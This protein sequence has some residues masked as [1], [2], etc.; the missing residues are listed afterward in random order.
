MA[1]NKAMKDRVKLSDLLSQYDRFFNKPQKE[2]VE[3]EYNNSKLDEKTEEKTTAEELKEEKPMLPRTTEMSESSE[4]I[5]I[6]NKDNPQISMFDAYA[7]NEVL[8]RYENSIVQLTRQEIQIKD[9]ESIKKEYEQKI[10]EMQQ[11]FEVDKSEL[12]DLKEKETSMREVLDSVNVILDEKDEAILSYE[13]TLKERKTEINLIKQ[14]LKE[15][16]MAIE[17][18]EKQ[19]YS[20]LFKISE[21]NTLV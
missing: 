13:Q 3:S 7:F 5:A 18:M 1:V 9:T 20:V 4:I 15:K 8:R 12:E 11:D 19:L 14:E 2:S 10:S 21:S 6:N 16:D 17:A